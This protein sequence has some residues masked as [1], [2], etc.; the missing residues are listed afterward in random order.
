MRVITPVVKAQLPAF[1]AGS[2][3]GNVRAMTRDLLSR[4]EA[5]LVATGKTAEKA[6]KDADLGREFVRTIKRRPDTVPRADNLLALARSLHTSVE[7]LLAATDDPT[8]IEEMK[9]AVEQPKMPI[10]FTAAAG[11]WLEID[12]AAQAPLGWAEVAPDARFP[13]DQWLERVAGDSFDR[14]IPDGALVQVADAK[15]MG[16]APRNGDI[17]IAVRTR[18]QGSLMERTLKQ[19]EVTPTGQVELWPRSH[20]PA[21]SSPIALGHEGSDDVTVEIA[22]LVL[23]AHLDAV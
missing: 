12:Q 13:Y 10:L 21:Y 2:C 19:V 15:A 18:A 20:N 5:R 14:K 22:A 16:Y 1:A 17:V 3:C 7:Y 11:P 6:S 8:P 23:R 9:G 4:I